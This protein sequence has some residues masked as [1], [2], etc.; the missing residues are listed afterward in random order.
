MRQVTEAQYATLLSENKVGAQMH[1]NKKQWAWDT[2]AKEWV[3]MT[4]V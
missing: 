1:G 4:A 3:W 2:D